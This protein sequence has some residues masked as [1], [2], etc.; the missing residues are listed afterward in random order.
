[1]KK[2]LTLT[3]ILVAVFFI[4]VM[5]AGNKPE[6]TKSNVLMLGGDTVTK[7]FAV[8]GNGTCKSTIESV[9]TSN[10][11]VISA[12]WDSTAQVITVTFVYSTIKKSQLCRAL[13]GAGYDNAQ[14]RTKDAIYATLPAACQYI[15]TPP[16]Q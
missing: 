5:S 15:R 6:L 4:S 13:A 3:A 14:V 16:T 8:S 12:S 11:G 9:V 7:S 10:A 2:P 1:M